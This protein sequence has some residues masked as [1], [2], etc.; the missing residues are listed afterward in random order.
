[1]ESPL[2]SIAA[3]GD[4]LLVIGTEGKRIR[5]QSLIL[6]TASTVFNAMLG[7]HYTEGWDLSSESPKD[8]FLPEDD[9]EALRIIFN[10]IHYRLNTVDDPLD[11]PLVLR[12]AIMA[13]KYDF[14]QAL[15]LV[16]RDWLRC[17]NV[18][19]AKKLWQLTMAS[20]WLKSEKCF[21]ENTLTLSR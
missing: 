13:D 2:E 17:E 9:P 15:K 18:V 5:V 20:G 21:E 14:I 4:V 3:S 12:I 7:P 16:S 8:I 19:D 6:R 10:T 1:M 11:P